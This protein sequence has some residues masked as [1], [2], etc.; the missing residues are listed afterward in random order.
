MGRWEWDLQNDSSFWDERM[1]ELL[2]LEASKPAGSGLLLSLVDR[3]DRTALQELLQRAA[4]DGGD[5]QTEFRVVRPSAETVWLT[6]CGKAI[7]DDSGRG[8]RMFGVLYDI[9]QRK[10]MEDQLR[11]LNDELEEE[12]QAQTEE[13]RDTVDRLHDEVGRRVGV[14]GKL[15]KT[16]ADARRLLPAHDHAAGLHGP[17]FQLHS[18]QRGLRGRPTA[19]PRSTSWA[20]TILPCTRTRRTGR[21]S[22]RSCGPNRLYRAHARPFNYPD[23]PHRGTTYWNWQLTPLLDERGEVQFLV[24]NLEDV[25]ERQRAFQELERR[26]RQLQHLTLELS[27]AEDRERRRLAE[28]LHDDLQQQLA[29]AKFH[30]GILGGRIKDNPVG[31]EH[32]RTVGPDPQGRDRQIPQPL[33]RA[34]SGRAVP[35]RPGRDVRMARPPGADQARAHRPRRRR[36]PDPFAV[37]A[38][39]GLSLQGGPGNPVQHRQACPRQGGPAAAQ[40]HAR[41]AVADHRGSGPGLR[42]ADAS[43]GPADSDCSA[44][45]SGSSC[46][47]AG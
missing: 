27:Q 38:A 3:R 13:L 4:A 14:E 25:T 5:F 32:G 33:A 6:L 44:F 16:L 41:Q 23:A 36:G 17:R 30:L 12:V 20:G 45:A 26:A 34:Q 2:G 31:A 19:S 10:Q 39:E 46:S 47:A 37:G 1:Y 21:S 43:S 8:P 42:S 7:L 28:I 22:S 11:R 18:R 15:R 40:T 24:L 9:T 29:A 35:Q